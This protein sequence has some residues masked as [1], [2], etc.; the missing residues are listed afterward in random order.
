MSEIQE[1]LHQAV[2]D[3]DASAMRRAVEMLFAHGDAEAL[4]A[5]AEFDIRHADYVMEMPQSGERIR[6]REAMQAMQEA[7][8][9]PPSISLR[10][11]VGSNGIWVIEGV[12]DYGGDV[13][14]VV[15]IFELDP[16]EKSC[17]TPA[18]TPSPSGR[19]SGVPSGRNKLSHWR[20]ENR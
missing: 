5:S 9:A 15:A 13:W 3:S 17:G 14:H 6:G 16:D 7:F 18:I 10:R 20:Q 8:P 11:V 4:S 12:N 1:L 19:R 2:R